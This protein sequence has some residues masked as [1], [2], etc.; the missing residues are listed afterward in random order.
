MFGIVVLFVVEGWKVEVVG[1]FYG[2]V[3]KW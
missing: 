1:R 2:S 3:V